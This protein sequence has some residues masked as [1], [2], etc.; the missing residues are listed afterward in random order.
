MAERNESGYGEMRARWQPESLRDIMAGM[1]MRAVVQ[2]GEQHIV[3]LPVTPRVTNDSGGLMG[4]MTATLIDTVAGQAAL[5]T[6]PAGTRI[7]TSDMA[8][9]YLRP[10]TEDTVSA[11]ATVEHSGRRSITVRVDVLRGPRADKAA[12]ATVVFAVL[13]EPTTP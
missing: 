5:A 7:T 4:G 6:K 10:A 1:G 11:V 12:I 9:R 3:D 8:I 13:S 2:R